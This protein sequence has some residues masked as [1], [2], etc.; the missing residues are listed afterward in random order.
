MIPNLRD[1]I[2]IMTVEK[3]ASGSYADRTE[4]MLQSFGM[5]PE[6]PWF[7][8]G[9]GA[10]PNLNVVTTLLANVGIVG[11]ALALTAGIA[12]VLELGLAR[13]G[14]GEGP[15]LEA[16]GLRGRCAERTDCLFASLL[17]LASG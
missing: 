15:K 14:L 10:S 1:A 5:F 6:A 17:H 4:R 16:G 12:T 9:W 8:H 13:T 11:T 7:R 2:L 3:G